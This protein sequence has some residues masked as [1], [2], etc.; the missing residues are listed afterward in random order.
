MKKIYVEGLVKSFKGRKILNGVSLSV[1]QGEVVGLLGP[2]GAG[3]TTTFYITVGLIEA[4]NGK[5]MLDNE[6]ITSMPMY[7]RAR[8]GLSYLPQ[9]PS[10]FRKLTVRDNLR[11][12]VEFMDLS[13]EEGE[14]RIA[15]RLDELGINHLSDVKAYA[16][17]GGE[18][19]RLEIARAMVTD[20]SFLLLDEPFAGIDPKAV[21]DIQDIVSHLREKGIGVLVTDHNVEATLGICDRAYIMHDGALLESGSPSE[22]LGS[23][24]VRDVYL[25]DRCFVWPPL[26]PGVAHPEG[27]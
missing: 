14:R 1:G 22:I 21:G 26:P 10:V 25:G 24:R 20:P 16:L 6:D 19:R 11:A 23:S 2:N 12:I 17:S 8:R 27:D 9:E 3:K 5:I 13:K 18:R 4:D 15:A 7:E